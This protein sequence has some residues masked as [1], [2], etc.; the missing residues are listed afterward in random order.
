MTR[1]ILFAF[2]FVITSSAVH[3]AK[4]SNTSGD[5]HVDG[6]PMPCDLLQYCLLDD[7]VP[8]K[9]DGKAYCCYGN[10]CEG[11]PELDA[12]RNKPKAP[13]EMVPASPAMPMD[14]TDNPQAPV[15][16]PQKHKY[17]K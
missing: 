9:I 1:Q 8:T 3:A 5:C 16:Q 17:Y 6:A 12:K 2:V 14:K 4:N 11:V 15:K 10:L 7:G 13:V